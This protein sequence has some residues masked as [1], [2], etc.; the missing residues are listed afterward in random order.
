MKIR[1]TRRSRADILSILTYLS[2][3][4]PQGRRNVGRAFEKTI[5][6]IGEHP[7]IG[8]DSGERNTRVLRVGRYPYLIYWSVMDDGVVIVHIRHT[9]RR[10]WR[11][12]LS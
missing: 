5:E 12:E 4:S 2:E 7:H 10:P 11:G 8:R 9:A 1:F 3:R 6:L